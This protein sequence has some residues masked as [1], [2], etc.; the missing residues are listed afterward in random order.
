[1]SLELHINSTV[2][3]HFF[4]HGP[5]RCCRGVNATGCGTSANRPKNLVLQ[6]H[7]VGTGSGTDLFLPRVEVGLT[8][9]QVYEFD[10]AEVAIQKKSAASTVFEPSTMWSITTILD[11]SLEAGLSTQPQPC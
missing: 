5:A 11:M 2:S 6:K 10:E 7:A 4:L 1:M 3:P 8:G 9:P